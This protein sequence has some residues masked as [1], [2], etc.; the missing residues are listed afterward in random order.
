MAILEVIKAPDPRLKVKAKPVAVV[1][2]AI[3]QTLED[4]LQTM[5]V[6]DGIGLAATQVGIDKRLLVIDLR[7][8]PGEKPNPYK[9]VNP[10]IIWN[11]DATKEMD[12]GCVSLPYQYAKVKRPAHVKVKYLDE[13]GEEKILVAEEL[14]A[15]CVQHEIDHLDGVL[16]VDRLSPLKRN[17]I[18]RRMLKDKRVHAVA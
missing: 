8:A 17:L 18:M 6:S 7:D 12:E 11:S 16:F 3:R 5:Y 10:E 13:N 9:M 2:D 1:D 15:A 4:M 14:M